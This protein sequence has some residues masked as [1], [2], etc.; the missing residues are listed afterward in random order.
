MPGGISN[1]FSLS[2][3]AVVIVDHCD[4]RLAL[5]HGA[6]LG[7][8]WQCANRSAP[9]GDA[10]C[11]DFLNTCHTLLDLT[12][13]LQLGALPGRQTSPVKPLDGCIR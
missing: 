3:S 13:P 6:K 10:E 12:G 11:S 7:P 5:E 1:D 2:R 4:A 9:R 8:A